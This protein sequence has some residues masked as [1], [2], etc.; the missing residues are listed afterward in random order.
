[1]TTLDPSTDPSSLPLLLT[2][3]EAAAMLR[4]RRSDGYEMAHEYLDSGGTAGMPV[5]RLSRTGL[6]VP[7]WALVILIMTGRVVRLDDPDA[8]TD[9]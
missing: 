5:M 3:E 6:R 4:V 8:A 2:V 9:Q 1:M 7:R